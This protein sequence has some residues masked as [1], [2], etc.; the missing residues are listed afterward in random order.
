M[1]E[2]KKI[3]KVFTSKFVGT[4]PSSCKKIIYRAAVSRRSRN[5]DLRYIRNSVIAEIIARHN[6]DELLK[7]KVTTELGN[8]CLGHGTILKCNFKENVQNLKERT[9]FIKFS[10][11]IGVGVSCILNVDWKVL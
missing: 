8:V 2:L 1:Y 11:W 9:E 5:T 10:I 7:K 4:V 3:G 6:G